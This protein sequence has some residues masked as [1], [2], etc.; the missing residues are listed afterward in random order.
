VLIV[1]DVVLVKVVV[2][3]ELTV[4]ELVMLV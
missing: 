1:E 4:T 2:I 3:V